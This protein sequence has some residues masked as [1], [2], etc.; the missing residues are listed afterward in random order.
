M[1]LRD[2]GKTK[3]QIQH[4]LQ[5]VL[6]RQGI[7]QKELA[8]MLGVSESSVSRWKS[9][10]KI[11]GIYYQK[12]K[13]L[14]TSSVEVASIPNATLIQEIT[15]RLET[16]TKMV[17]VLENALED[18]ISLSEGAS[19]DDVSGIIPEIKNVLKEVGAITGPLKEGV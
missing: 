6:R 18:F 15:H 2:A 1:E 19:I 16:H 12:L 9:S 11:A 3:S 13:S 5:R 7:G 10:G 8:E 14:S 17:E 4:L